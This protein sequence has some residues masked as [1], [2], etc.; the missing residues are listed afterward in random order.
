MN[1]LVIRLSVDTPE[2]YSR[3]RSKLGVIRERRSIDND[4]CMGKNFKSMDSVSP[5]TMSLF[6]ICIYV[7]SRIP[8][9]PQQ[10]IYRVGVWFVMSRGRGS[11]DFGHM[12]TYGSRQIVLFL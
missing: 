11:F 5:F 7:K 10:I 8:K 2:E 3:K 6:R 1:Y 9:T 4:G 12:L